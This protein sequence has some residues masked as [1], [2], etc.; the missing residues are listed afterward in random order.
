MIT[1][2]ED[3]RD[4]QGVA[5]AH[6][7]NKI[8]HLFFVDDNILFYNASLEDWFKVKAILKKYEITLVQMVNDQK[9]TLFFSSNTSTAVKTT[10]HYEVGGLISSNLDK[11]LGLLTKNIIVSVG[12]KRN[13]GSNSQIGRPKCYPKLGKKP[14]SR[15]YY[16]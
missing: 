16:K 13:Y 15:L 14:L 6:G 9:F 5:A 2:A 3:I 1:K 11:C 4:I 12:L 8:S 7:V 10:V